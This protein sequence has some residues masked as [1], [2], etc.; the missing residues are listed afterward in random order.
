MTDDAVLAR[1]ARDA[2]R[3]GRLPLGRPVRVWGGPGGGDLCIVCGTPVSA[4]E[5]DYELALPP[6]DSGG[7]ATTVH[8]HQGC[9][10]A[11]Q[12]ELERLDAPLSRESGAGTI[13]HPHR[14]APEG[15]E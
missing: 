7:S 10:R 13:R 2:L 11:W 4:D 5:I 6:A 15:A 12:I 1:R 9:F 3:E 14:A 8:L